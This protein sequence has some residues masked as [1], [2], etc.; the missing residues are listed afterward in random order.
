M[1]II[2]SDSRNETHN[3]PVQEG[4]RKLSGGVY[5]DYATQAEVIAAIGI[6]FRKNK[7]FWINGLRYHCGSDGT[8][9][10]TTGV[11]A[12]SRDYATEPLYAAYITT[13]GILSAITYYR[14][15]DFIAVIPN[16]AII[17]TGTST[18]TTG[19]PVAYYDANRAFISTPLAGNTSYTNVRL[20]VPA[21]V[22]YVRMSSRSDSYSYSFIV[23]YY[24]ID[25]KTTQTIASNTTAITSMLTMTDYSNATLPG[26][27]QTTD[28][29]YVANA[30]YCSTDFIPVKAGFPLQYLGITSGSASNIFYYDSNQALVQV[31]LP[32]GSYLTLQN[33]TV[34]N[35]ATIAFVRMCGQ[36]QAFSGQPHTFKVGETLTASRD[37]VNEQ[38]FDFYITTG[39]VLSPIAYYKTSDLIPVCQYQELVYTGTST[40]TTSFP[41]AY[42]DK[43][44]AFVSTPLA[45]LKSYVNVRLSVP[46][47]VAYVRMSSRSDGSYVYS[48]KVLFYPGDPKISQTAAN[49]SAA[50]GN[51]FT[52]RDYS[53]V[54][55]VGHLDNT[56]GNYIAGNA[57][58]VTTDFIA[59][60]PGFPVQYMGGSGNPG[61]STACSMVY[62]DANKALV[63]IPLQ[64][65]SYPTLLTL[66]VPVNTSAPIAYVRMC[67]TTLAYSGNPHT[68]AVGELAGGFTAPVPASFMPPV[69]YGRQGDTY[70]LYP[71][72]I[73]GASMMDQGTEVL[74]NLI[75][76]SFDYCEFIPGSSDDNI[77]ITLTTRDISNNRVNCGTNTLKVTHTTKNPTS[78]VNIICL[79]DSVTR[80]TGST[81]DG[82]GAWPNEFSRRLTGVGT[83]I[84]ST[85]S[86]A[87]LSLTNIGIRGTLGTKTIKHEGRGGWGI[88]HYLTQSS[89]G[90]YTNAFW[91]P[92]TSKFDLAYYLQQNNFNAAQTANG[93]DAT[94]SNLVMLIL[95]GWNDLSTDPID[96]IGTN[97]NTMLDI[98]HTSHPNCKIKLIGLAGPPPI[99]F[100]TIGNPSSAITAMLERILPLAAKWQSIATARSSYVEFLPVAPFF[101]PVESF[102]TTAKKV[103]NRT[104]TTINY[105]NDYIHPNDVGYGQIADAVFYAFLYNY[106][107]AT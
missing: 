105:P 88:S 107:R 24:P 32:T 22:S 102:A 20:L 93:V 79:G 56:T 73:L 91:N 63:M 78:F 57:N 61:T 69:G 106:C 94:G 72:G 80:G 12:G 92:G 7:Y 96:T 68:F 103:H 50:I 15:T 36:T 89:Y 49:N 70:R 104:A 86:P 84:P 17:Y 39:G 95:L 21:G 26:H 65:G 5:V 42:Y 46:A 45:G 23:Q 4:E 100:R 98:I 48:F 47:G 60:K 9:F 2:R 64:T 99:F 8:T 18:S 37:F 31:A 76:G 14:T 29:A 35:I 6:E 59:T 1:S 16:Q 11:E 27:L 10:R 97:L 77:A 53:N 66:T 40:G 81:I 83:A 44:K 13:G 25:P 52:F 30:N 41:V 90:G 87:A 74:W 33:L 51:M 54:T 28:G 67:S 75:S 101:N 58:L 19:Y 55:F 3:K 38:L 62:Y 43:N 34:P 71:F 82:D 85:V